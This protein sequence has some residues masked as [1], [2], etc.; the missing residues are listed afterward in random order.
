MVNINTATEIVKM[1]GDT[2]LVI[3]E[4][5][6]RAIA[7]AE[8]VAQVNK[9]LALATGLAAAARQATDRQMESEAL[10]QLMAAQKEAV[11]FNKGGGD[12]RSDHRDSEKP[13]GPPTLA[14]AGID[15]NL[16]D[17][18]RK[19]AAMPEATFEEAKEAKR[20]AVL[21]R[22]SK[23]RK[24]EKIT[25]EPAEIDQ[26]G[27][28]N[29]G[30]GDGTGDDDHD[31]AEDGDDDGG[32]TAVRDFFIEEYFAKATG[33][34]ILE[35]IHADR[36]QEVCCAFLDALGVAGMLK[37][38]SAEFGRQ[39]R[40]RLPKRNDD[41]GPCSRGEH[42]RLRAR[43]EELNNE[44][45][46]LEIKLGALE[47]EVE[48]LK[49]QAEPLL[50]KPTFQAAIAM[51][52]RNVRAGIRPMDMAK[53]VDSTDLQITTNYLR[54]AAESIK[55]PGADLDLRTFADGALMRQP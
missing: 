1:T 14:E 9:I 20:A 55:A 7:D 17:K 29:D 13:G 6:R 47:S 38:M 43:V 37:A 39:L 12:Q 35:Q 18:A 48:H 10:G 4:D 33:A 22:K 25:G 52:R 44:K 34:D 40:A 28:A 5:A 21:T 19:A 27:G 41:S 49:A 36:R 24:P 8:T 15:K 50:G 11:G 2:S 32:C 45:R 53:A 42:D 26:H 3:F 46:A 30:H 54:S 23:P 31:G 51:L 16:A